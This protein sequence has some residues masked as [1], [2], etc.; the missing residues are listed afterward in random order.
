M[1]PTL[2]VCPEFPVVEGYITELEQVGPAVVLPLIEAEKLRT[3][4]HSYKVCA[5]SNQV[6]LLGHIEKLENR[7]GA[8]RGE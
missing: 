6:D 2:V 3:W 1:R 4:I 7:L 8:L 5:E